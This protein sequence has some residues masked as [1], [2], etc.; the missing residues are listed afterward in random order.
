MLNATAGLSDKRGQA[1][2]SAHHLLEWL[3]SEEFSG[4]GV[5]EGASA[6]LLVI[7]D[8]PLGALGFSALEHNVEGH[9]RPILPFEPF[10]LRFCDRLCTV[11]EISIY[12][13][14]ETRRYFNHLLACCSSRLP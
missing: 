9:H 2:R 10:L 1:L 13:I 7:N 11:N 12:R 4:F 8:I 6:F 5:N 3:M 14:G